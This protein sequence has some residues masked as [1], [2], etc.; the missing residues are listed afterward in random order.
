ML[1]ISWHP[2]GACRRAEAGKVQSL[3]S[4]P[5]IAN[6]SEGYANPVKRDL[7]LFFSLYD[8]YDPRSLIVHRNSRCM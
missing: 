8:L 1:L 7:F 2:F 5:L 3:Y 4:F 6:A